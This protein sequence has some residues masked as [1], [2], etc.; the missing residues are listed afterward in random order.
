MEHLAKGDVEPV[1]KT[2]DSEVLPLAAGNAVST[3]RIAQGIE[4][5]RP[6]LLTG[7]RTAASGVE[8][9]GRSVKQAVGVVFESVNLVAQEVLEWLGTE[10]HRFV[11]DIAARAFR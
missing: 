4:K 7:G 10:Q 2:R 1:V 11:A 8:I 9:L 3:R 6:V 5:R